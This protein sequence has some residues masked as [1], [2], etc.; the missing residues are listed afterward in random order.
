M[1]MR[2]KIGSGSAT[3]FGTISVHPLQATKNVG[4][5]PKVA[6]RRIIFW[7][8]TERTGFV[9]NSEALLI[10]NDP[11]MRAYSSALAKGALETR[12]RRCWR[13][14]VAFVRQVSIAN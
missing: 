13:M 14:T 4:N 7:H 10:L 1:R 11:L 8:V 12:T 6:I 3:V 5:G 9:L 2:A